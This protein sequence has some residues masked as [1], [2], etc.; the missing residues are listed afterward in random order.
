M[1]P[2]AFTQ[3]TSSRSSRTVAD[4]TSKLDTSQQNE[5]SIFLRKVKDD[6]GLK[7]IG[8]YCNQCEYEYVRHEGHTLKT[9]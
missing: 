9:W 2:K 1:A 6:F 5:C 3:S 8:A 7:V 4:S